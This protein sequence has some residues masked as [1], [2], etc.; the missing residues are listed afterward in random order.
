MIV[1]SPMNEE[2]LR[3]LM[4]TAQQNDVGP[5]AIRYP[6]GRGVMPQWKTT[7]KPLEI[8]KGRTICDGKDAVGSAET[9]IRP[10]V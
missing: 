7:M 9:R 3:N 10:R 5:F 8:G 6:K 1:A 4:Y 2:E